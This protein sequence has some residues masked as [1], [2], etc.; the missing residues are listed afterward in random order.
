[1]PHF[2]LTPFEPLPAEINLHVSGKI[3]RPNPETIQICYQLTGDLDS[4]LLPQSA[5]P[6]QRRDELW[7]TTCLELFIGERESSPYWELNVSPN[8]D[9]NIYKL[10]NYRSN[11]A[12]DLEFQELASVI[13]GASG[14]FELSLACPLP[15]KLKTSPK[16]DVAICAVIQFNQ[17]PL[18]YW[19]LQHSGPEADFHR[20]DDFV[21]SL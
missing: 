21:L 8:G 1:M 19:A 15:G 16:L 13:Q 20:R 17:G 7:T 11:L 9:W 18:S 5:H 4:V 2:Q 6:A 10:T 3:R 14:H 12:P